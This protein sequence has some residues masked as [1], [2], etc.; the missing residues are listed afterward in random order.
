[1]ETAEDTKS[2]ATTKSSSV[3]E[4]RMSPPPTHHP[5]YYIDDSMSIFLVENQL[6]KVHRHFLRQES[7][8][9]NSMFDSPPPAEGQEGETDDRP[10][11]LPSITCNE[12]IALLNR[13]YKG[14][15]SR[16]K[17]HSKPSLQEYTDLLSIATRYECSQVRRKAIQ[18]IERHEPDATKKIVLAQKYNVEEWLMPAYIHLCKRDEPL[19]RAEAQEIG[20]D[21][22]IMIAAAREKIRFSEESRKMITDGRNARAVASAWPANLFEDARVERFIKSELSFNS[23]SSS[24]SKPANSPVVRPSPS[25]LPDQGAFGPQTPF[26]QA[27]NFGFGGFGQAPLGG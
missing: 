15:F 6:F 26:G 11:V 27:S 7:A 2:N 1:M 23:K 24:D 16:S 9:F 25:I 10:I 19:T 22:A 17:A 12:F 13:I 18:G 3:F 14:S 21:K 4:F 5:Q 20:L 8:V